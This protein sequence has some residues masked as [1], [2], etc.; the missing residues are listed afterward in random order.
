MLF[1]LILAWSCYGIVREG[2]FV[3][4]PLVLPIFPFAW[5]ADLFGIHYDA[6]TNWPLV[7]AG[8]FI[9]WF[10]FGLLIKHAIISVKKHKK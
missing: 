2:P 8:S 3:C 4:L 5:I 9:T 10:I 7:L 6:P 1:V